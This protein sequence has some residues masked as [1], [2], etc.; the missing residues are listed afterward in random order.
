[1]NLNDILKS[2]CA[3]DDVRYY[4]N[5]P[6]LRGE[7]IFATN[8]HVMVRVPKF[9]GIECGDGNGPNNIEGLM[10]GTV[11]DGLAPIPALPEPEICE[12]CHGAGYAYRCKDCDGEGAF[13]RNGE[14]YDCKPCDGVGT[15]PDGDE[16]DK[17]ECWACHGSGHE[18]QRVEVGGSDFDRRYLAKIIEL[19]G[20]M[21]AP[22]PTD[23]RKPAY[24]TFDGGDGALMPM[25]K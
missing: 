10:N 2:F 20:A 24:F 5:A 7:F 3:K 23:Q 13:L 21:F 1:M 18:Q 9:D 11:R 4:M 8:G 25:R 15:L 19:P 22:H 16:A 14:E 17:V 6:I 12:F